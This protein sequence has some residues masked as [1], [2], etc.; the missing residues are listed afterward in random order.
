MG[1]EIA[2]FFLSVGSQLLCKH[3]RRRHNKGH[4]RRLPIGVAFVPEV[5]SVNNMAEGQYIGW[6]VPRLKTEL[7]IRGAVTTGRKTDLIE[8]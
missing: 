7:S 5:V 8:R 6:T 2:I 4:P 1:S 3:E